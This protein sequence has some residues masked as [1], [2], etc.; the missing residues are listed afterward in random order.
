MKEKI[1]QDRINELT[2]KIVENYLRK[3]RQRPEDVICVD[4]EGIAAEYFGKDIVYER[5]AEKDPGRDA[6]TANGSRPLRVMRDGRPADIVFPEGTIVLDMRFADQSEAVS[7]RFILAHEV[8][9]EIYAKV[10]PG[11]P[12][13]YYHT[14]F[15]TGRIYSPSELAEQMSV[16]EAQASRIGCALLMPR[17]LVEKTVKEVTGRT[18]VTVYGDYQMLPGGSADLKRVADDL[19]VSSLM[20]MIRLRRLGLLEYRPIEEYFAALGMEVYD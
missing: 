3:K 13:G 12:Q 18:A 16:T 8:G 14:V 2:E 20:L 4:I 7:R 5:F 6:F 9:H 1:D 17:F 10:S 11:V 15:D 19:G